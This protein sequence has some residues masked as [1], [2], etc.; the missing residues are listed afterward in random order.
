M[1]KQRP[2]YALLRRYWLSYAIGAACI[3]ASQWLKLQIPRY[4]WRTLD[5]LRS[6]ELS[7]ADVDLGQISEKVGLAALWILGAAL[8]IAPVRT[9]S[10]LLILG[11]SRRFSH[12]LLQRVFDHMLRLAPSFYLRNPTGQLMSRCINDRN[13]VRSLGGPVFMYMAETFTLYAISVPLML[14]IDLRLAGLA[15]LPYPIFLVLARVIALHIQHGVRAAQEALGE[16]SE[17]TDESLSGQL[18]IKTLGIESGDLAKFERCCHE[19]RRQNLKVTRLR[20]LLIALMMALAGLST[21]LVIALGGPAVARGELT[22]ADFGV[23][24]TYL[25]W[26]A[27]PTRTL[28]FVISSLRRGMA[29]YGRIEEILETE[30][31]LADPPEVGERPRVDEGALSLRG[32]TVVYPPRSQQPHLSGSLS[33][34]ELEGELDVARTVLRDVRVEIPAGTTLGVV[35]HTGAGK[36]TLARA[37]ARQLEIAPGQVF[38]DGHDLT[39]YE[40]SE[41]RGATGYVPQE[42]FL[43]GA[44]LAENVALGRP[45]ASREEISAAVQGA[46]LGADLD[47]LPDGLDTILGERGVNLSGGQRQRTALARVLLLS[48]RLLILDDT[49]SAVDTHTAREILN[50]LRPFASQRT[51]I[52][53]AHRLSTVRHA[54][55]II[56]LEDGAIVE[57]GTHEQLLALGGRYAKTWE[58]QERSEERAA[59]AARLERELEQEEAP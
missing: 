56:V 10:R 26:L 24:L 17:K 35:G 58:Q 25:A 20:A 49:L 46:Q 47:Q 41:V 31:G 53:I 43:F 34:E 23:L 50:Y 30:P 57:Q 18:V 39:S 32:L 3:V 5:E 11:A 52:L 45:D 16:I 9:A 36:T 21:T 7:G 51:T 59:E 42:A 37:L 2:L 55:K 1:R 29:A 33:Q 13:Y 27:V 8:V 15:I 28:G 48:P 6:M 40:L 4:F 54:E 44:S 19:Y 12:D 14:S 22:F 38:L